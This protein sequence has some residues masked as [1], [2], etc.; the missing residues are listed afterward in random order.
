VGVYLIPPMSPQRIILPI[1][2]MFNNNL[3]QQL[4]QSLRINNL[5]LQIG[6]I[7]PR[8][9]LHEPEHFS[10]QFLDRRERGP[11]I[12]TQLDDLRHGRRAPHVLDPDRVQD[13]VVDLHDCAVQAFEDCKQKGE[14]FDY[15]AAAVDIDAVAYV[16]GVLLLPLLQKTPRETLQEDREW[17][18]TRCTDKGM[19]LVEEEEDRRENFL[20]C[21]C[22]D[23]GQ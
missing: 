5:D 4:I 18:H 16:E 17:M 20:T 12:D 6:R 2:L 8:I 9:T 11:E 10:A 19:Y 22:E 1:T 15:V 7:I 14:L 21:Y 13:R 3:Q 23:E